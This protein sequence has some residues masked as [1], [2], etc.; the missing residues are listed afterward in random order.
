MLG[1]WKR[2]GK[3]R[4]RERAGIICRSKK[5]KELAGKTLF[6]DAVHEIARVGTQS[7][8]QPEH[9]E[10]ILAAY[11][12]F[13]DEPEFAA[14]ATTDEILSK[15]GDLTVHHYVDRKSLKATQSTTTLRETWGQFEIDGREFWM[16]MDELSD[17]LDSTIAEEVT[18][19]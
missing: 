8:L 3:P 6:I 18:D 16:S 14:V 7:F 10:K 13:A 9:Q 11:R 5:S 15:S 2:R 4:H 19:V 17:T 12:A 1:S